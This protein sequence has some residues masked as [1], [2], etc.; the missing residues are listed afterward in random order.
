MVKKVDPVLVSVRLIEGVVAALVS[1][2]IR[3][4]VT[5]V[6][7]IVDADVTELVDAV[8]D[9]VALLVSVVI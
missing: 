8:T 5:L 7:N 9:V 1:D 3:G 6:T 2:V 4:E